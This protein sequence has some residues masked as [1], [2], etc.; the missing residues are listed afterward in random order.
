[1]IGHVFFRCFHDGRHVQQDLDRVGERALGLQPV[2]GQVD[3]GRQFRL[4]RLRLR[5]LL[6][7]KNATESSLLLVNVGQLR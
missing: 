7:D 3:Y 1:M 6:K 4:T 5:P 2:A